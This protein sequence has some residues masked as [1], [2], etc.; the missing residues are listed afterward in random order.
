LILICFLAA[1]LPGLYWDQGPATADQVKRA[2]VERIY[3]P[4]GQEAAWAD[5]GVRVLVFDPSKL[6]KVPV[7]GVEYKMDVAAAT[8]LPWVDANG[9]RFARDRSHAYYYHVPW[10]KAELA[11]AEAYAYGVDAVIN[12]DARDLEAFGRMLA[13]LRSIDAPELPAVA[14]IGIVDD[15]SEETGEVLNL[16]AR[17]N[18]LF[19][20]IRAPDPRYDLNVQIGTKEYPKEEAADPYAFATLLRRKLTDEKRWLRIFGS[21]VVL[22]RLAG[23]GAHMRVHLV[24]YG[25]GKVEGLRVRVRGE[26]GHG[27]IAAFGVANGALADYSAAAGATEFTIPAMN[28]YAVVDLRK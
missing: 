8:S 4:A 21:D 5:A 17:R 2:G 24:N 9:W 6:R 15:G 23:D 22:A 14:N 1:L 20:V 10:R 19:E 27:E 18:L 28:V 13:F 12:P 16:M 11:A 26:Y 3:V 25:G 7:P